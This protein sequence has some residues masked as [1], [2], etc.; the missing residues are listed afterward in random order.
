MT[1]VKVKTEAEFSDGATSMLDPEEQN[2]MSN[3]PFTE[4]ET[5]NQNKYLN[6]NY[7]GI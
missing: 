2:A 4:L 7:A 5:V 1:G 3:S 6:Q